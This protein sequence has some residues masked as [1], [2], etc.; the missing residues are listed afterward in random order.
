MQSIK[1]A[2]TYTYV[3]ASCIPLLHIHTASYFGNANGTGCH[4]Y[5]VQLPAQ[6]AAPEAESSR[7]TQLWKS[8]AGN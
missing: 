5:L 4:A 6:Q 8:L 2:H 3:N 7:M 1:H